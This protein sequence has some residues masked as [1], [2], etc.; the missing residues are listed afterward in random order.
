[1]KALLFVQKLM[2]PVR[3]VFRVLT[4][5]SRLKRIWQLANNHYVVGTILL[6]LELIVGVLIISRVACEQPAEFP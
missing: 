3:R 4:F 6:C 5:V 2:F 1:M